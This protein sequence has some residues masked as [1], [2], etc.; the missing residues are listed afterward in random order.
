MQ[1]AQVLVSVNVSVKPCPEHPEVSPFPRTGGDNRVS[2]FLGH[3][4]S[5]WS[6]YFRYMWPCCTHHD[7][8]SSHVESTM[9]AAL[10]PSSWWTNIGDEFVHWS[11]TVLCMLARAH[12]ARFMPWRRLVARG[13]RTSTMTMTAVWPKALVSMPALT[14]A[15]P[16]L[17]WQEKRHGMTRSGRRRLMCSCPCSCGGAYGS[18]AAMAGQE[19]HDCWCVRDRGGHEIHNAGPM[20][21]AR[22]SGRRDTTAGVSVMEEAMRV[23]TRGLRLPRGHGQAGGHDY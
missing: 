2:N 3:L 7:Q 19:G 22:W 18:R 1:V 6:I 4:H 20:A 11:S 8:H 10:C 5:L 21:P 14:S 23:T 17:V 15:V 9:P 16:S 13:S 12:L